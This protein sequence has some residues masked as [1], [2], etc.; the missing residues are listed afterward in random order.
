MDKHSGLLFWWTVSC[1]ASRH[2]IAP[3]DQLLATNTVA[4]MSY[5]RSPSREKILVHWTDKHLP[6]RFGAHWPNTL[7]LRYISEQ[8]LWRNGWSWWARATHEPVR[9]I[10][11]LHS[12]YLPSQEDFQSPTSA[13]N[14]FSACVLTVAFPA[15]YAGALNKVFTKRPV[16]TK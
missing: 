7:F 10:W 9:L 8:I 1:C 2:Q 16:K 4:H 12:F 15:R 14:G 6:F 3:Q 13:H 11:R 5:T